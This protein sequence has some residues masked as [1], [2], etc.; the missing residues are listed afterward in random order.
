M[1]KILKEGVIVAV[2]MFL[3]N[4]L[5]NLVFNFLMPTLQEQYMDNPVF[6]PWDDPVMMLFWAYPLA[7]GIAFAWVWSKTK[8]LFKGTPCQRGWNFG[9]VYFFI[10]GLP[11]FI[12]NYSSFDLPFAMIFTWTL[13]SFFNGVVAGKV[14]ARINK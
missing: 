5:L 6:R 14:L 11:I 9:L 12:I 2:A 8:K 1:K 7:L 3:F 10:S 4:M 13:M